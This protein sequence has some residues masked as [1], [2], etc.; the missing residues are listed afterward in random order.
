MTGLE[1]GLQ[2]VDG[3]FLAIARAQFLGGKMAWIERRNMWKVL[4]QAGALSQ[5]SI[6]RIRR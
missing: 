4:A 6:E 5:L 2:V 3:D 1:R